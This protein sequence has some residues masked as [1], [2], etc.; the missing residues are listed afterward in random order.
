MSTSNN[1][2]FPRVL[3]WDD[4]V[5]DLQALLQHEDSPVYIVGGAVRDAFMRR[6]LK[7]IDLVTPTGG[8]KL[9]RKIANALRGDF[10]AL[11]P[12]RDVGR[13]LVELPRGKLTFDVAAFRAADIEAD[14][15]DRDF[16]INAMAVDIRGDLNAIIDPTG[17]E[18]DLIAKILRR[19]GDTAIMND[20]IRALRGVRQSVKFGLRIEPGTLRDMRT[21]APHLLENSPERLRD[22][23]MQL[24]DVEKPDT[25]LRVADALG[26]LTLTVP[27]IAS[28]RAQ[29]GS[30][31]VAD[32]LALAVNAV[33]VLNQ[34]MIVISPRRTDETAA[35][36][37]FGM[38]VMG[39]D[40]FRKPLQDH[41]AVMYPNERTH[42]A[43]LMLAALLWSIDATRIEARATALRLSNAEKERW[44]LMVR[45][46]KR[47]EALWGYTPTPT[48]IYRYWRDTGSAGI[49]II[50]LTLAHY[51][52]REGL[53]ID[54]DAWLHIVETA[55]V[56]LDAYF[57]QR[58]LLVE[59]PVL[60][61]GRELMTALGLK[62]G[63]HIGELLE[64]IRE[65]QVEGMIRSQDDALTFARQRISQ[66]GS[67]GDQPV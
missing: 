44:V 31:V 27:E 34:I 7:D 2:P 43:L 55:R 58:D 67:R 30:G 5:Y 42:R 57:M 9:A 4:V 48:D 49:D 22:E 16:T 64:A 45:Q 14:L 13:A 56:L 39:V 19:C 59:P 6:P 23:F 40:I 8:I 60:L 3:A 37:T 20:P 18:R 10:Y 63:K 15:R 17:G 1:P 11:D 32:G 29:P 26:L 36:F 62:S 46:A 54:Q 66:N 28:I 35:Q 41:I 12:E 24:L 38:L 47:F 51:L 61:D 50:L 53:L 52:A 65:M 25:A 33:G 21:A